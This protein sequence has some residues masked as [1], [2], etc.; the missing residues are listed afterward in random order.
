MERLRDSTPGL[1][2][3]RLVQAL[4][5]LCL[6]GNVVLLV[7]ALRAFRSLLP[8]A[9]GMPL[10][11]IWVLYAIPALPG[12]GIVSAIVVLHFLAAR[13]RQQVRAAQGL[14][15]HCGY[16]LRSSKQRCP[17]CGVATR[18]DVSG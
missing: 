7:F 17:E 9:Q 18:D 14:C 2:K 3:H 11:R 13:R 10:S 16:D 8:M 6:L 1:F 15:L 12:I 4:W 5:A